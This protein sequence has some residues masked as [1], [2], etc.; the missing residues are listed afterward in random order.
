MKRPFNKKRFWLIVAI[1]ALIEAV[2]LCLVIRWKYIFPSNEV[3]DIYARYENVEGV[4]V[5]FVKDFKVNDTVFVDVT[6]LEANDSASWVSLKND[7]EVP[8]PSP[9][10]QQFIDNGEDLI[11]VKII[12]KSTAVDTSSNEYPNNLLAISHLNRT[13]T[14]FHV[15]N[16]TELHVVMHYNFDKSTNQ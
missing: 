16:K 10:F 2:I 1:L 8:N 11:Y 7:F 14:V 5:S 6:I 4:D 3:S 9:D 15:K 13:L 12:P